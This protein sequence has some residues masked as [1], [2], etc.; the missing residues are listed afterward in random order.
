M[1]LRIF[2]SSNQS[3]PPKGANQELWPL[4]IWNSQFEHDG[5]TE[6]EPWLA[7]QLADLRSKLTR[8]HHEDVPLA[9][10]HRARDEALLAYRLAVNEEHL[11][12]TETALRIQAGHAARQQHGDAHASHLRAD[13]T[14]ASVQRKRSRECRAAAER[15]AEDQ[16]LALQ[17][18]TG[19]LIDRMIVEATA[20][21]PRLHEYVAQLNVRR[22]REGLAPLRV[23]SVEVPERLVLETCRR[24]GNADP[25]LPPQ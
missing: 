10:A 14:R 2:R 5:E 7:Q 16:N 25:P 1:R 11:V 21:M 15:Q 18:V 4:V 3:R 23:L 19:A 13:G 6:T 24:V 17:T 9:D 20:A 8:I 22:V 12:D